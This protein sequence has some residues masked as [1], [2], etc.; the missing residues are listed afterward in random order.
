MIATPTAATWIDRDA[1]AKQTGYP[2]RY[3]WRRPGD[4]DPL[5]SADAVVVAPATFNT[6]NK[7]ALGISDN[8]ALG[9]LN[10]ALGLGLPIVLLPFVKRALTSHPAYK[11]SIDALRTSRVAFA[12]RT[13]E[14]Q[15][16][17]REEAPWPSVLTA[18]NDL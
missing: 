13:R 11:R 16:S 9:I 1:L 5:P 8:V 18:I 12:A 7:W 2:V 17:G 6:I 10:E 14:L 15:E 3:E 4:P